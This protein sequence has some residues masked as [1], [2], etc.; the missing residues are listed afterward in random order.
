M[1]NVKVTVISNYTFR[2]AEI[3]AQLFLITFCYVPHLFSYMDLIFLPN[4]SS[5]RGNYFFTL[6]AMYK[7]QQCL[8]CIAPYIIT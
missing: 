7:G 8:S 6:T 3:V 1:I 5:F 2:L 4:R